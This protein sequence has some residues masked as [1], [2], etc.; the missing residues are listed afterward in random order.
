VYAAPERTGPGPGAAGR[1]PLWTGQGLRLTDHGTVRLVLPA[2]MLGAGSYLLELEGRDGPGA[3]LRR[4]GSYRL[5]IET[6]PEPA[7]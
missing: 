6:G 5:R 2:R 4:V 7:P 1:A 3:A